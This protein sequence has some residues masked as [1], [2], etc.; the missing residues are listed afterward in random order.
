MT[1]SL[2]NRNRDTGF[3]CVPVAVVFSSDL[4]VEIQVAAKQCFDTPVKT[5]FTL[6]NHDTA[7][8]RDRG[9]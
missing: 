2:E 4:L 6:I 9:K 7:V 3:L 8:G 5:M 1:S